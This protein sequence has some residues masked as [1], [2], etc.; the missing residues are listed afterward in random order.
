[1]PKPKERNIFYLNLSYLANE[2]AD[3][4]NSIDNGQ[5]SVKSLF[6]RFYLNGKNV[7]KGKKIFI[8][9]PDNGLVFP[10]I[11]KLLP[12]TSVELD[13]S[14][15]ADTMLFYDIYDEIIKKYPYKKDIR[16]VTKLVYLQEIDHARLQ[17]CFMRDFEFDDPDLCEELKNK[18]PDIPEVNEEMSTDELINI[19]NT[20]TNINNSLEKDLDDHFRHDVDF[21]NEFDE[22]MTNTIIDYLKF[23]FQINSIDK[24]NLKF[25]FYS[26]CLGKEYSKRFQFELGTIPTKYLF[27]DFD[28]FTECFEEIWSSNGGLIFTDVIYPDGN[29]DKIINEPI[30]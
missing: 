2:I 4:V 21:A 9:Y 11:S 29:W 28:K 13:F 19:Y 1:M 22:M 8:E 3:I 15:D 30:D 6:T 26:T 17:A 14:A 10:D 27:E 16:G 5:D 20:V 18:Y 25:T 7:S 12:C 23:G 24:E